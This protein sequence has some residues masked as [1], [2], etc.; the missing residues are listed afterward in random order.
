M[1]HC[2]LH[3]SRQIPGKGT[4]KYGPWVCSLFLLDS[5]TFYS[6]ILLFSSFYFPKC[7]YNTCI[8]IFARSLYGVLERR[9]VQ[10]FPF[11][12]N[13]EIFFNI[14]IFNHPI[15]CKGEKY[16]KRNFFAQAVFVYNLDFSGWQPLTI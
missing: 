11:F 12:G 3:V 7:I 13:V 16:K 10:N 6:V 1:L 4:K 9:R 8:F 14:Y 2:S 5:C 15:T